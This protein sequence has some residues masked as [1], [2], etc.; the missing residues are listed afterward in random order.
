MTITIK[1]NEENP[2]KYTTTNMTTYEEG[3]YSIRLAEL[4]VMGN[5]AEAKA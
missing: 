5:V 1:A 3:Y 2:N 4:Y